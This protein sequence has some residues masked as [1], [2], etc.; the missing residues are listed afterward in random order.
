MER[1]DFIINLADF[2]LVQ[3]AVNSLHLSRNL[4]DRELELLHAVRFAA[5]QA[6]RQRT[7]VFG[8]FLL[9]HGQR[10]ILHGRHQY[11]LAI[12]QV[13]TDDVGDG[14]GLAGA[15]RPLHHN[16]VVHLQQLDDLHLLVVVRLG[17]VQL[18]HF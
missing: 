16:P 10:R 4:L 3:R 7:N 18:V 15:G 11:P 13:M 2:A 5:Q 14:V 6:D 9:Q 8:E 1:V 17:E 12:G